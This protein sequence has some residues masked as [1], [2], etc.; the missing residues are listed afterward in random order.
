M[1]RLLCY[2]H[3]HISRYAQ[4]NVPCRQTIIRRNH[5]EL[6]LTVTLRPKVEVHVRENWLCRNGLTGM[7]EYW[8]IAILGLSE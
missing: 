6:F 8:N 1:A 4:V 5:V 2:I 7:L 3:P